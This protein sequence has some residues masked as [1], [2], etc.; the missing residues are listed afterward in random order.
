MPQTKQAEPTDA[1][2]SRSRSRT[3]LRVL[4]PALLII[5]WLAG[6][7][8]GGPLFGKIGEVATNDQTL[9][10]PESADAAQVQ[11]A[12]QEFSDS[13]AIPAIVVFTSEQDLTDEERDSI[14]AALEDAAEYDFVAEGVSPAIPS[15]DGVAAQAFLPIDNEADIADAVVELSTLR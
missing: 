15:E 2:P 3:W 11:Q 6:A 8:F 12:Q 5:G 4:V 7:G 13:D 1:S 14:A 10:L 9:Y